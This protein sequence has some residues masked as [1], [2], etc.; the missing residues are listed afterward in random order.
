MGKR[1]L[2]Q[3][4]FTIIEVV[5]VLAI[6]ALIFLMVLIALPALQRNQRDQARR[7][8]VGK[9]ASAVTTYQS[10]RRGAQPTRGVDLASY[11]DGQAAV[12]GT[13]DGVVAAVT[14]G[15]LENNSYFVRVAARAAAPATAI[16]GVANKTWIQVYTAAKCDATGL[17]AIPGTPKQAAVVMGLENG[18]TTICQDV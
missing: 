2:K 8:V 1:E 4:G 9:V 11:A 7:T 6:A 3:K 17:G 5:L 13:Y 15:A 18:N 12:A 10:N 16:T 14:D